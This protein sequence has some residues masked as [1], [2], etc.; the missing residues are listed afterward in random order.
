MQR[1][2][3]LRSVIATSAF[4]T[5]PGLPTLARIMK[6]PDAGMG[7]ISAPVNSKN[8]ILVVIRLFGGNDGLNTLVPI[9]DDEYYRIRRDTA[10]VDMSIKA[11]STIGLTGSTDLAFH[12]AM[13]PLA[14]LY[15]EKKVAI[16]QGVG[17][18]NM[19][20]SHFRGTNI[21]LSAS[22]SNVF[23]TTG[24]MGRFL[25][26]RHERD[27]E[28][29]TDP[30]AIEMGDK[31]GRAFVGSRSQ[32]GITYASNTPIAERVGLSTDSYEGAD[33]H[34][35]IH[36]QASDG[37]KFISRTDEAVSRVPFGN[38]RYYDGPGNF[39]TSLRTISRSIRGGL[40]TQLYIVHTGQFDTHSNQQYDHAQQLDEMSTNVL[41]FQREMEDAGLDH[42][43]SVLIISEFGRRPS[44]KSTGTDHGTAA[45]V[46]V[47]GSAV[48]GGLLGV[49][50]SVQDLNTDGNLHWHVDFRSIY[51]SVLEQWF[52][53]DPSTYLPSILPRQYPTLPLFRTPP[54]VADP[55][56]LAW[57]TP[58]SSIVNIAVTQGTVGTVRATITDINGRP[59]RVYD[60]GVTD[61]TIQLNVSSISQGMY[62]VQL[63]SGAIRSAI[64]IVVRR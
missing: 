39:G 50:P 26:L 55:K 56:V 57:P 29:A 46:F 36:R 16:V 53:D 37:K 10:S 41:A 17:Y 15:D 22:D 4:A 54:Q 23:E 3:F 51:A 43:V 11:E 8:N 34:D 30:F 47:V 42:R 61:G 49:T 48:N 2:N 33:L 64:P 13:K 20:L 44:P 27:F 6:A 40:S 32:M 63:A 52:G 60:A 59:I 58:C 24:W 35:L 7:W 38:G 14:E 62:V 21:W 25:E 28:S 18:P 45:P 1:R 19:D 5:L 31:M 12:P 9:Q